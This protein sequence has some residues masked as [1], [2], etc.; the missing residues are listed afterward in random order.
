[1]FHIVDDMVYYLKYLGSPQ[2]HL[3]LPEMKIRQKCG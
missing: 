3:L 2:A 1:M